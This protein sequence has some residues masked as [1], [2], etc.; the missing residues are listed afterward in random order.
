MELKLV[1]CCNTWHVSSVYKWE[2]QV[3]SS[4][5]VALLCKTLPHLKDEAVAFIEQN[6]SYDVPLILQR[7]EEV[8]ISYGE[9]MTSVLQ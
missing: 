1:A 9:W 5:E 4:H 7:S 3:E 6:H 8:N 2:D